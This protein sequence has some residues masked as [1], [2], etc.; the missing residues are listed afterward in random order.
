M[1]YADYTYY[2][3]TYKGKL[4]QDEFNSAALLA[5]ALID[6]YTMGRAAEAGTE[7]AERLKIAC[8]AMADRLSCGATVRHASN[9]GYSETYETGGHSFGRDVFNIA[10]MYLGDTGLMYAGV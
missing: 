4:T 5:S 7:Y 1:S 10:S 8:C 2:S 3:G 9:D 6:S